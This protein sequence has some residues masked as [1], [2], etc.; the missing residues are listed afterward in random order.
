MRLNQRSKKETEKLLELER[1]I[2]NSSTVE[3]K[4][5][6]LTFFLEFEKE[7]SSIELKHI[8]LKLWS[9]AL[10]VGKITL[11]NQYAEIATEYLIEFKRIPELKK[12]LESLR[13][14]GLLKSKMLNY[15]SLVEILEGKK[16]KLTKQDLNR[17]DLLCDHPET[18]KENGE[19]LKNYLVLE[20]EWT[21]EQWKLGYEYVLKN[22]YDKE[23]FLILYEKSKKFKDGKHSGAFEKFFYQKKI[24][25][26][27]SRKEIVNIKAENNPK[28]QL[29]YDQVAFDLLSG[30]SDPN[31]EEQTRVINSL[32]Y[33]PN[34]EL[35]SKGNEM[36]VAFELLGMERVVFALCEKM[37]GLIEAPKERASLYFMWCQALF[38]CEQ[39]HKCIDLI[40]DVVAKEP[41]IDQELLA[42]TY[43]KAESCLKINNN[44]MAKDLFLHIKKINPHYRLV[45]ERLKAFEEVK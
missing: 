28:F 22:F 4:V 36:I 12:L 39:Y 15:Y 33:I 20:S 43:L 42:F 14:N 11:A 10:A 1:L 19:F 18:W 34:E 30:K 24:K 41:L 27:K 3:E 17:I 38:N 40:T 5:H 29:N 31:T 25:I 16:K 9:L 7:N 21:F 13:E 2:E 45:K 44:K 6:A 37:I 32:K 23:L 35:K 26:P 8:Y